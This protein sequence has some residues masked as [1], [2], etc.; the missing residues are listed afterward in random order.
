VLI[1]GGGDILGQALDG[2]L[3]DQVQ[4]YLGSI[5]TGGP[6]I[7]FGGKGVTETAKAARLERVSYARIGG[8][9][10]VTGYPSYPAAGGIK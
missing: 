4:I 3:V 6:T 1:E 5:L 7:A 9:V 8:N 2:Q 10:H